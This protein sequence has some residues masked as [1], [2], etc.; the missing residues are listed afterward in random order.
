[1]STK[2]EHTHTLS[3]NIHIIPESSIK[4]YSQQLFVIALI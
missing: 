2:Y 3:S 1:M 4:D